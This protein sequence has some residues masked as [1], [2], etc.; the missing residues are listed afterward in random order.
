MLNK[1]QGEKNRACGVNVIFF[2]LLA[3][4][5]RSKQENIKNEENEFLSYYRKIIN[6]RKAIKE[7][8]RGEGE[9]K[10]KCFFL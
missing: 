4:N 1:Q 9:S 6:S 10:E 2:L 7:G 3:E 8:G 5:E